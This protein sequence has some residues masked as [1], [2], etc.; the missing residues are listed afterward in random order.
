MQIVLLRHNRKNTKSIMSN[1]STNDNALNALIYTTLI[2]ESLS[3]QTTT[4][5]L[6]TIKYNLNAHKTINTKTDHKLFM[7]RLVRVFH[8]NQSR[9]YNFAARWQV[10]TCQPAKS[11]MTMTLF[12]RCNVVV[13]MWERCGPANGGS[14]IQWKFCVVQQIKEG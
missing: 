8:A 4:S 11:I 9:T 10:I 14:R 5:I 7:T 3:T 2:R 1:H 6:K 12:A 13:T